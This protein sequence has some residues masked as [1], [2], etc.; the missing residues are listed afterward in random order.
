MNVRIA[1]LSRRRL[2]AGAGAAAL[3]AASPISSIRPAHAAAAARP[4]PARGEFV[5]RKAEILSFDPKLGDMKEADIHVRNGEIVA[6]GPGLR[7]GGA[8]IAGAGFIVMPGLVDTHNHMWTS[9]MRAVT[10]DPRQYGYFAAKA[11]FGPLVTP[12]DTYRAT[13]LTAL[14]LVEAGVTAVN[15]MAN[16]TRDAAHAEAS[17]RATAEAGL[18]GRFSYGVYEGQKPDEPFNYGEIAKVQKAIAGGLGGGMV[19]LGVTLRG[20]TEDAA[21]LETNRADYRKAKEMGLPVSVDGANSAIVLQTAKDGFLGPD[22]LAVHGIALSPE[23]RQAMAKAGAAYST[24]PFTELG[25]LTGLP[26]AADLM[27]DGVLCTLSVD[28]TSN[29]DANMFMVARLTE[30]IVRMQTKDAF[31]FGFKD[32]LT[33]ATINGAKALGIAGK[34]GSLTP[35]KRADLIMVRKSGL[36]ATPNVDPYRLMMPAQ[37]SDIDTV[38]ADGRILKQGGKLTVGDMALA[39]REAGESIT[40]LRTKTGWP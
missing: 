13:R 29:N 22:Y 28:S 20:L 8:E 3:A 37:I 9:F 11:K 14:Q 35:G 16:N 1:H 15:D 7:A 32:A 26:S 21:T 10:L 27:K 23:A 30:Y 18:R 6:V 19:G 5:I 2:M 39:M 36:A 24:S 25:S 34:T 17:I 33:M 12:E 31:T 40:A 4:L 38:V